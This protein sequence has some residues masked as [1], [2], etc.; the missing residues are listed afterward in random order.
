MTDEL[1]ETKGEGFIVAHH[2]GDAGMLS[3]TVGVAC[4]CGS[5]IL[6][7]LVMLRGKEQETEGPCLSPITLYL[8]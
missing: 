3:V 1:T 2:S 7:W 4:G 8:C 5:W 6:Q